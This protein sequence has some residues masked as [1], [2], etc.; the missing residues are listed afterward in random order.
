[1]T[2]NDYKKPGGGIAQNPRADF[3]GYQWEFVFT[4]KKCARVDFKYMILNDY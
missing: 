2:L 3:R 4:R 1:M